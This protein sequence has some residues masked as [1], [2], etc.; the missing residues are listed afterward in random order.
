MTSPISTLRLA[1]GLSLPLDIITMRSLVLGVSG[2][3][4]STFGRL[5]A[6]KVHEAGQRFCVIDLKNDWWGLKSSANGKAP[7]IPV[8]VLG[9]PR[10]DLPLDAAA[11][12]AGAYVY[13]YGAVYAYAYAY[14]YGDAANDAARRQFWSEVLPSALDLIDRLIAARGAT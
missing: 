14:A 5:L 3:G 4:K 7:A 10:A 6:E 11:Y 9:G 2:S 1:A 8:V 12:A 13:A